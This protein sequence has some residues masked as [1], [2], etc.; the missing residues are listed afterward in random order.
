MYVYIYRD[1]TR[2]SRVD[3][4]ALAPR[5]MKSRHGVG[6]FLTF[7]LLRQPQTSPKVIDH[8]LRTLRWVRLRLRNPTHSLFTGQ[9][10]RG[11]SRA[12]GAEK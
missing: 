12:G 3:R 10:R 1:T 9:E 8:S 7:L 11:S 6:G 4:Q 5:G 2:A